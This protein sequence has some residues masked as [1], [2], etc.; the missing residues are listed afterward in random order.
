MNKNT[1]DKNELRKRAKK[2]LKQQ[3]YDIENLSK[4]QISEIIEELQIHQIELEMQNE[5]LRKVQHDLE[6]SRDKYSNLYDFSPVGYLTID[7]KGKILEANLTISTILG[8]PRI[9]L[10]GRKLTHFI[11]RNNQDIFYVYIRDI[12]NT[13]KPQSCELKIIKKDTSEFHVQLNCGLIEYYHEESKKIRISITDVDDRKRKEN[14]IRETE[15]RCTLL[16]DSTPLG[17]YEIDITTLKFTAVN[18]SM[19]KYTGYTREELLEMTVDLLLTEESKI[20]M[21]ERITELI[22]KGDLDAPTSAEYEIVNKDGSIRWALMTST[23]IKERDT[24]KSLT[25]IAYDLTEPKEREIERLQAQ[26]HLARQER[27]VLIGQMAGKMA[28]DFNNILGIIM[29]NSELALIECENNSIRQTLELIFEQTVRGRNL[30][31]NLIVFAKDNE[32]KQ[33]FFRITKIIDSIVILMKKDL[34]GIDVIR[35]DTEGVPKILADFNMT[36]HAIINLLQNSIHA[37]SMSKSPK[38]I[39]R[40]YCIDEKI[41]FEIED[42]GCGIP[43]EHVGNIY[44]PSLTLKGSKDKTNSYKSSIRGTGYGMAN[45]KKYVDQHKG[46][47]SVS[48]KFGTGTKITISLPVT[49]TE[50]TDQE[51]LEIIDSKSQFN[52]YILIV[53]DEHAISDIQYRILT[54][55]PCNHRVDIANNGK[56]AIDLLKRN[57]YDL[58]SLDYILPGNING[59]DVYN[60][61]RETNKSI[62]ILFI[63]GNIEFLESLKDLKKKDPNV[64][65][66]SKPHSNKEYVH[67][68]NKLMN[69]TFN[70]KEV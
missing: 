56:I 41:F 36:E 60:H 54:Q 17:V 51:K 35:Q 62:P 68:L 18:N 2:E 8:I 9:K 6:L 46:N 39:I 32:P 38:I 55:D 64:E 31:K 4:D 16:L 5:E 58:I 15:K 10:I 11:V 13:K 66:L 40:T 70:E 42:N 61:I 25:V 34:N 12:I 49:K 30:T 14:K 27:Q 48:T 63:S 3:Q 59:M 52:K 50:L 29:G 47:I 23:F 19:I 33:E 57:N 20:L 69:T 53:E 37:L 1:D 22:N 67:S 21:T 44:D 26:Q 65:N 45:I 43:E 7:E 24:I 28:H